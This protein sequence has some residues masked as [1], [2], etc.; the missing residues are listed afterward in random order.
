MHLSLLVIVQMATGLVGGVLGGLGAQQFMLYLVDMNADRQLKAR[1]R[2]QAQVPAEQ[3][4]SNQTY[5]Q[6]EDWNYS[7][8]YNEVIGGS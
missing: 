6:T 5:A 7:N 8:P 2:I 3:H 4:I 1:V